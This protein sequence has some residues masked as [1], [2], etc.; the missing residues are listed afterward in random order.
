MSNMVNKL[1]ILLNSCD[2]YEDIWNPFFSLFDIY[3]G[4]LKKC[5]ILLNTESKSYFHNGLDIQTLGLFNGKE[6]SW[7]ERLRQ[8]LERVKTEYVLFLMEDFFLVNNVNNGVIKRIIE[9]MDAD[10]EIGAFNLLPLDGIT[11]GSSYPGFCLVEAGTPYRVNAQACIW[12]KEVLYKS[13]LSSENPWIWE[14]YGRIRNDKLLISK[15][16]C[17]DWK[18]EQPINYNFYVYGKCNGIGRTYCHSGI[19]KGRWNMEVVKKTFK[20]NGIAVNYKARGIYRQRIKERVKYSF[21]LVN[22]VKKPYKFFR[23][24]LRIEP[25]NINETEEYKRNIQL[26]VTPYMDNE[27]F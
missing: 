14:E 26:Y 22:I 1:T 3:A 24:I 12:R 15:I 8:H 5:K 25:F 21:F 16:Y 17:L 19:I 9:W 20:K 18:E 27:K 6:V 2:A 13:I 4:E 23:K 7:G 10:K 11:K